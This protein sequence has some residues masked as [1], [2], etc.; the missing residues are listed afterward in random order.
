MEVHRITTYS[1][2]NCTAFML[3]DDTFSHRLSTVHQ[4]PHKIARFHIIAE[5]ATMPIWH[6]LC[7]RRSIKRAV[8]YV[9][10][11]EL[12]VCILPRD[13]FCV[14]VEPLS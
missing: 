6:Y 7:Q 10:S 2:N 1:D 12:T 11:S 9:A 5:A 14:I 8:P 3:A 13:S 4:E